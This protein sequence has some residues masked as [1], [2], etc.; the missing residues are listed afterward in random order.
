YGERERR[1]CARSEGT[2]PWRSRSI[3]RWVASASLSACDRESAVCDRPSAACACAFVGRLDE[4]GDDEAR[5]GRVALPRA[6]VVGDGSSASDDAAA[7][8]CAVAR[9]SPDAAAGATA[10]CDFGAGAIAGPGGGAAG[11]VTAGA[12]VSSRGASGA[13]DDVLSADAGAVAGS[14]PGI[15]DDAG[16]F[17]TSA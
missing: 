6:R 4:R 3:S 10:D 1:S 11:G 16:S 7:G 5:P 2:K 17:V 14:A 13:V 15:S 12:I 9:C 8:G